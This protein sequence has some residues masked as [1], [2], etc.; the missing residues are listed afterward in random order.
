MRTSII[1]AAVT[2]V[3]AGCADEGIDNMPAPPLASGSCSNE[4]LAGFVGQ[5]A[6]VALGEQMLTVSGAKSLRWGPPRTPMTMDFREDRLTVAY[7]DDMTI[8]SARCG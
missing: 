5:K 1:T 2:M 6:T 4:K 3:L 8:T 7:D